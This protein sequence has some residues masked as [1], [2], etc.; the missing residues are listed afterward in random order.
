MSICWLPIYLIVPAYAH[1]SIGF[2][3]AHV[4][5]HPQRFSIHRYYVVVLCVCVFAE[6]CSR[7]SPDNV[8]L[9]DSKDSLCLVMHHL[10]ICHVFADVLSGACGE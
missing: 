3:A 9:E 6:N 1:D 7:L 5:G 2:Q 4:T 8:W 10:K